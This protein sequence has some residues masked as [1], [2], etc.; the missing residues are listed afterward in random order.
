MKQYKNFHGPASSR[1]NRICRSFHHA[2]KARSLVKE[3]MTRVR[4]KRIRRTRQTN[5][6]QPHRPDITDR[7][8]L[9]SI[10]WKQ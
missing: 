9:K 5:F 10:D 2:V 7:A 3:K 4:N 1:K 8:C 6:A